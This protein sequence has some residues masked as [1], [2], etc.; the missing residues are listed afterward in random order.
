MKRWQVILMLV[1]VLA[2]AAGVAWRLMD[3]RTPASG[4]QTLGTF[5]FECDER[6]S[7]TI[8]P[9]IDLKKIMIKAAHGAYPPAETLSLVPTNSGARYEGKG[10]VLVGHGEDVV[11]GEGDDALGCTQAQSSSSAPFDFGN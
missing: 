2:A 6:V 1:I 9:S 11:L 8:T 10:V 5:A 4:M 7:F 3:L